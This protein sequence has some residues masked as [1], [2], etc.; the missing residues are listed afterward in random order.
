MYLFYLCLQMCMSIFLCACVQSLLRQNHSEGCSTAVRSVMLL[1]ELN[2]RHVSGV[3]RYL[4]RT[5]TPLPP[6]LLQ[7]AHGVQQAKEHLKADRAL[8]SY[9]KSQ[10]FCR[11]SYYY[12]NPMRC[13]L[14]IY[15][16]LY[17]CMLEL[18][19]N[20][21][22]SLLLCQF[23]LMCNLEELTSCVNHLTKVLL[24]DNYAF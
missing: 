10:G 13:S 15:L 4:K 17:V 7:F 11:S 14:Y 23:I 6:E 24:A 2:S 12:S 18:K 3:L 1:S 22:V 8:C 19:C 16:A 5:D 20:R 9:L 21:F